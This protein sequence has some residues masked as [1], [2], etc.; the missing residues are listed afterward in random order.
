MRGKPREASCNGIEGKS[1]SKREAAG[2]VANQAQR[3]NRMIRSPWNHWPGGYRW[4]RES[5][6]RDQEPGQAGKEGRKWRHGVLQPLQDVFWEGKERDLTL[7]YQH[8]TLITLI[9]PQHP[10]WTVSF[11]TLWFA[12]LLSL[13]EFIHSFIYLFIGKV[14]LKADH[15]PHTVLHTTTQW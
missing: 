10:E 5:G 8:S 14:L 12:I 4:W 9:C 3:L 13:L 11:H 7:T 1:G 15:V 6:R 2:N